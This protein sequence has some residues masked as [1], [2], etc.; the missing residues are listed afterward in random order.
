MAKNKV[1]PI[2]KQ[3]LT[4]PRLELM[5]A[6][7]AT[8]TK[9]AH[10]W[11]K[12][13]S[14]TRF[15]LVVKGPEWLCNRESCPK[16]ELYDSSEQSDISVNHLQ[17]ETTQQPLESIYTHTNQP[18]D[19]RER[20]M[21]D[22]E[23][24]NSDTEGIPAGIHQIIDIHAYNDVHRLLLVTAY[25]LRFVTLLKKCI[26]NNDKT[27]P[28]SNTNNRPQTTM[29]SATEII[30]AETVWIQAIQHTEY[31]SIITGLERNNHKIGPLSKQLKLFL[32]EELLRTGGRIQNSKL[33][34]NTIHLILLP[35]HHQFTMMIINAT[36]LRLNHAGSLATTTA[37]C[38]RERY[39]VPSIRHVVNTILHKCVTCKRVDGH[40][41]C[42]PIPAPLP[43]YHVHHTP[44]FS[45]C[46]IDYTGALFVKN[47]HNNTITKAYICLFMC[48]ITRAIHLEL[49]SDMMTTTF[50]LAFRHFAARCSTPTMLI[51]DNATTF[52]SAAN[53]LKEIISDPEV[54]SFLTKIH[55]TW[56][57]IPKRS[58]WFGGLYERMVG[59]T[60]N[61]LK[62]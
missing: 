19:D 3:T 1:A 29:P 36:H 51:T 48:A 32:D 60:K 52:V 7:I 37:T 20:T 35:S 21:T 62:K 17:I 22:T 5:G 45:T 55:T 30:N 13:R 58:P 31:A 14:T 33:D 10:P 34:Y 9:S 6:V 25:V 41:Y 2:K 27:P 16:C 23:H 43:D 15:S 42:K 40:P 53:E 12:S 18:V 24:N 50:M 47:P 26:I 57:F 49:V 39:W 38:I 54:Q 44:P 61:A 46:G 56:R 28:V 8:E 11:N 59:I 4:L